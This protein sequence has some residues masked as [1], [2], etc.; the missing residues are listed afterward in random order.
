MDLSH[1][2]LTTVKGLEQFQNLTK[3]NVSHNVINT[4]TDVCVLNRLD[5]L[6]MLSVNGNPF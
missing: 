4:I 1:N 6:E 3:L 2:K 5:H